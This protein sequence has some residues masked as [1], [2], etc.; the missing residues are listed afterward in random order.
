MDLV[1]CTQLGGIM[2]N[3]VGSPLSR[4]GE[5]EN[6]AGTGALRGCEDLRRQRQALQIPF[7]AVAR[8]SLHDFR[9]ELRTD[10][11]A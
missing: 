7:G 1:E 11:Q 3:E 5:G 8:Q 10:V 4:R 9:V 6:L 2:A